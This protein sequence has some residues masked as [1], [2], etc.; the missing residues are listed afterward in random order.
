[1]ILEEIPMELSDKRDS[2]STQLQM[3]RLPKRLYLFE[4]KWAVLLGQQSVR[5]L[6][7]SI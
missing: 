3:N 1:V 2:K 5:R 6:T 7:A 4:E